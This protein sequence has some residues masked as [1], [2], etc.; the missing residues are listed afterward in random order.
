MLLGASEFATNNTS[1]TLLGEALPL[2]AV[3]AEIAVQD[4]DQRRMTMLATYIRVLADILALCEM[5]HGKNKR[6]AVKIACA[7]ARQ[8]Q[9][10]VHG[11]DALHRH[12]HDP[13]DP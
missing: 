6:E 2:W 11:H 1:V 8:V 7:G 13:T 3:W 12:H 10:Y 9:S 5:A 4:A